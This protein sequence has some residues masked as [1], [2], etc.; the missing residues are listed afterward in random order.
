AIA[1]LVLTLALAVDV[2]LFGIQLVAI[3]AFCKVCLLTYAIGAL[4]LVVALPPGRD[5]RVLGE[6]LLRPDGRLAFTGWAIA[7]VLL[8]VGVLAGEKA[9][10]LRE[11]E[12]ARTI[13]GVP[14]APAPLAASG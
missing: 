2:A 12:R 10:D 4:G 3:R 11:H 1:L 13:L 8:A 6:A 5:G 14:A 9:L 7:T